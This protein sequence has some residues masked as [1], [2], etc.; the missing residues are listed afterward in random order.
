MKE[1]YGKVLNSN[2][3]V[4]R[5]LGFSKSVDDEYLVVFS[6][7]NCLVEISAERYYLPSITTKLIDQKGKKYSIRIIREILDKN[8]LEKDTKELEEIRRKY[9]L[10]D[11]NIDNDL[12]KKGIEEYIN[13]SFKQLV[14]FLS[15]NLDT[16]IVI[17][18]LFKAEYLKREDELMGHLRI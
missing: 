4:F 8:N 10:D 12:R 17:D 15:G 7:E 16:L 6:K 2:I 13:L 3:A 9:R 5:K 18:D 11:K 1:P 14:G